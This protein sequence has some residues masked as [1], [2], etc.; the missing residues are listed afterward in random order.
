LLMTLLAEASVLM[1]LL[2]EIGLISG[3]A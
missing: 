3:K 2:T 1:T